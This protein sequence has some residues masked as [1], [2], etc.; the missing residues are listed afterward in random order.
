MEKFNIEY[1]ISERSYMQRKRNNLLDAYHP[2][3]I[4]SEAFFF[5]LNFSRFFG[6]AGVRSEST[7]NLYSLGLFLESRMLYGQHHNCSSPPVNCTKRML[8][9]RL[10]VS[11]N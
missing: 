5:L 11:N 7:E 2:G 4:P 6:G 3:T 10:E 1:A 9:R 8:S